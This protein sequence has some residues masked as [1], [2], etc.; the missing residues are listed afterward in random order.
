LPANAEPRTIVVPDDFQTI[1]A[2]VGSAANGDTI[3]VKKGTCTQDTIVIGKAV[4]PHKI[5]NV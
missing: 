1:T 4:T 5:G 2:A 3:Y